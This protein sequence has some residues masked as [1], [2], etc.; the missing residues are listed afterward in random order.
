MRHM[1]T[2][3]AFL[4]TETVSGADI[5]GIATNG[6]GPINPKRQ[7]CSTFVILGKLAFCPGGD[8]QAMSGWTGLCQD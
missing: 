7:R 1:L 3:E 8:F 2:G 4:M 5:C 6:H